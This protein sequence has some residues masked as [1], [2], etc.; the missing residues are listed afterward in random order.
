MMFNNIAMKSLILTFAA[1]YVDLIP[2]IKH[3]LTIN[4]SCQ[5]SACPRVNKMRQPLVHH[6]HSLMLL[7]LLLQ[8]TN[9]IEGIARSQGY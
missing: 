1:I 4:T 7:L 5:N 3:R 9:I 6:G 2:G 8:S